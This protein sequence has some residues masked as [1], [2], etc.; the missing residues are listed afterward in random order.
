MI[1]P[2]L[3]SV[4]F[5][6]FT[7]E[8]VIAL[9]SKAELAAIEWGGDV[10][11]PHGDLACAKE[12]AKR[13]A[14]AGIATPTY[15]SYFRTDPAAELPEFSAVLDSAQALGAKTIRIWAG[16]KES[17]QMTEDDWKSLIDES[18]RVAALA[19]EAGCEVAFEYHL[20]TA[21]D[22]N[23]AVERL[24]READH[25]AVRTYW[26]PRQKLTT[27][28]RLESL[29]AVLPK[30]AHLHVFQWVGDPIERRPLAEGVDAW[31]QYFQLA[32]TV[33][34]ERFAFLEFVPE[35]SAQSFFADAAALSAMLRSR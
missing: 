31:S 3:C 28:E 9:V 26:Q 30:L 2:G 7:A 29:R 12:I 35:D 4:T 11:V 19:G 10:H 22:D 24:L 27:E 34:G 33:E 14:D 20:H 15:G 16:Q 13:C 17:A 5:R 23:A 8:E 1:L 18:L 32:D 25:P 21:T 6:Q